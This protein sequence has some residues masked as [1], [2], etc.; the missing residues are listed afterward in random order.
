[1]LTHYLILS[2]ITLVIGFLSYRIFLKTREWSFL[3]G[4]FFVYYWSVMGAWF[5]VYDDLSNGGG[6]AFG[7][8]HHYLFEKLFPV[9]ADGVYM[10]TYGLYAVFIILVQLCILFFGKPRQSVE[11]APES[12]L[13]ISHPLLAVLSMACILVSFTLVWK[14]ILM[15]AWHKESIYF[16]TRT[17]PG[18]LNTLHQLLNQLSVVALFIGLVVYLTNKNG[19]Y[20]TGPI[21]RITLPLYV[22]AVI[23]VEGG[24]LVLG[25]KREIFF[26]GIFAIL[27]YLNSVNYRIN[28]KQFGLF[29]AIVA[30]PLIFNDPLRKLSPSF[31]VHTVEIPQEVKQSVVVPPDKP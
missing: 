10:E 7:L 14:Q 22:A 21:S 28:W 16:V 31:L 9:H 8:E 26:G 20:L 3:A 5:L 30:V 2:A 4:I 23:L 19:R 29:G 1:M 27:F 13:S 24:L 18:T 25:N 12:R 15:A 6:K 17:Y 11:A